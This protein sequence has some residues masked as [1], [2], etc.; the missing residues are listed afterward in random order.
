MGLFAQTP[1]LLN[2]FY[3]DDDSTLFFPVIFN[4]HPD[5]FHEPFIT[6]CISLVLLYGS[7]SLYSISTYLLEAIG[8]QYALPFATKIIPIAV[9]TLTGYLAFKLGKELYSEK[10]AF[11]FSL[12][13]LL[14]I[15]SDHLYSAAVGRS[16][17]FLWTLMALLS[18]YRKKTAGLF[19]TFLLTGLFYPLVTPVLGLLL[20]AS[21]LWSIAKDEEPYP[22]FRILPLLAIAA[23]IPVFFAFY[24]THLLNIKWLPYDVLLK[25]PENGPN[26][27]FNLSFLMSLNL[28]NIASIKWWYSQLFAIHNL[29]SASWILAANWV[30]LISI[31]ALC[32]LVFIPTLRKRTPIIKSGIRSETAVKLIAVS[33]VAL[34][35]LNRAGAFGTNL[36]VIYF[37]ILTAL[38]LALCNSFTQ[39]PLDRKIKLLAL[40]GIIVFFLIFLSYQFFSYRSGEARRAL[41]YSLPLPLCFFIAIRIEPFLAMLSGK[42]KRILI[43]AVAA[44]LLLYFATFSFNVEKLTNEGIIEVAEKAPKDYRLVL[45][46]RTADAVRFFAKRWVLAGWEHSYPIN[47]PYWSLQ[48][49]Y[50]LWNISGYYAVD[51]DE[52]SALCQRWNKTIFLIEYDKFAPDRILYHQNIMEPFDNEIRERYKHGFFF[53]KLPAIAIETPFP[54]GFS[55]SCQ[56]LKQTGAIQ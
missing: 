46:P 13:F 27:R 53:E 26:G 22:T 9:F 33:F 17:G 16:T 15:Q 28:D 31:A 39:R 20:F 5:I 47:E 3:Y 2:K 52:V 49:S 38:W 40:M 32:A 21:W 51:A 37:Y 7:Y 34:F 1:L 29:K 12:I 41:Y 11:Y 14:L 48:K 23:A 10:T 36:A 50:L 35:V 8:I 42:Y 56:K 43:A 24:E 6:K 4:L 19:A 45:H 25:M 54:G 30:I 44:F 55:T 18:A